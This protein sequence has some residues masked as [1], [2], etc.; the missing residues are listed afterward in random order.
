MRRLSPISFA[1]LIGCTPIKTTVIVNQD[2]TSNNNQYTSS[3]NVSSDQDYTIIQP[4]PTPSAT[5]EPPPTDTSPTCRDVKFQLPDLPDLP[6][7]LPPRV[8]SGDDPIDLLYEH[9]IELIDHDRTLRAMMLTEYDEY[10]TRYESR[11]STDTH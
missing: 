2:M 7:L 4:T 3:S 9:I 11:C 1:F 5:D 8:L 6:E 10:I